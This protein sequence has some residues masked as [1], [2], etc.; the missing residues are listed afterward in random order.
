MSADFIAGV[1]KNPVNDALLRRLPA[2]GLKQC[3]LTAGCLFQTIWNLQ[4]GLPAQSEIKDYDVFYFDD[5]DLSWA[6]EDTAIRRVTTLCSDLSA[7]IE[8]KNQARVHLWYSERF[9][10]P[11]PR[12]QSSR[13]GIDRFL[14]AGSCIGID[15][16]SGELYAPYGLADITDGILRPNPV[17][18][19]P[20]LFTVKAQDYRKRWGWLKVGV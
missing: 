6:A 3:Y 19:N 17:N 10:A 8:V 15:I 7:T 13:D 16:L 2:L 4:S 14:I 9:G 20:A 1:R 5:S 18:P 12:L 11:Y